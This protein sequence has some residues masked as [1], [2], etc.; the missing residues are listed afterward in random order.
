MTSIDKKTTQGET[1]GVLVD[2]GY[3]ITVGDEGDL[4]I[5]YRNE[6]PKNFY[7]SGHD[8]K[9][10]GFEDLSL[11][12]DTLAL[13]DEGRRTENARVY[14]LS[15][16]QL[17]NCMVPN[18]STSPTINSFDLQGSKDLTGFT[19]KRGDNQGENNGYEGFTYFENGAKYWL[20][21][22]IQSQTMKSLVSTTRME[23][24][25]LKS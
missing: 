6:E 9:G 13:L 1:S 24:L 25:I 19:V 5:T 21:V 14:T 16:Q 10:I 7:I 3:R 18:S 11:N 22:N 2:N 8:G 20:H 4:T 12:G 15:L 23:E 17:K